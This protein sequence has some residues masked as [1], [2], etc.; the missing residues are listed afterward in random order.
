MLV[1][2]AQSSD[3]SAIAKL[4]YRSFYQTFRND[5]NEA[6]V[7]AYLETLDADA[8]QDMM[9]QSS[10]QFLV[11]EENLKLHGMIQLLRENPYPEG[12]LKHLKVERLYI[13]TDSQG[14]GIGTIL[15]Q[16]SLKKLDLT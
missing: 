14:Q 5:K 15:M 10:C 12:N 7:R 6:S 16:E 8:I 3:A 2:I 9:A 11:L 13:D 4:L 1:R